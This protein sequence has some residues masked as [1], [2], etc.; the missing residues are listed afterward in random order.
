MMLKQVSWRRSNRALF[1]LSLLLVP[2]Y[3]F[4]ADSDAFGDG[5]GAGIESERRPDQEFEFSRR[6]PE[7]YTAQEVATRLMPKRL[8]E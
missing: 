4:S 2:T 7:S 3:L 6:S 5:A 1:L 8:G